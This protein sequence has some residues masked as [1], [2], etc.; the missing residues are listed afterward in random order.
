MAEDTIAPSR[1]WGRSTVTTA[2]PLDCPDSCSLS[3]TVERGQ[4]VKIDGNTLAPSTNGYICGKV[5]RF[6]RRVYSAERLLHP[7]IRTGPKGSATFER[8]SWDE[9]LEVIVARIREAI[10][11]FGAESVL[12]Y[13]YGGSN[14]LLTNDLEDARFFRRLGASRLARTLCAA[15]TGAAA[16]AMYGKMP[17][18]AYS[19]YE[20]ARLVV[21]WGSNPSASGIHLVSHIKRAQNA[22]AKLVVIDP[23][24]TPLARQ[25]D[26]HLAVRPG[27]DLPV[28]LSIINELFDRGWADESFLDRHADGA[29][30]LRQAAARWPIARAAVEAGVSKDALRTLAEWY[31]TISPAVIRCGWGQ[32]RNRNGGSSTLAV[33]ALPAVGG[34]FGVR[35]GGYT[36]SNSS[37]W[38]ITAEQLIDTPAPAT[39]I[40][41]M[42]QLGRALT[43][44]QNP[45]VSVL[46]VYN[47][48]PLATVP[49]QNRV[50]RGLAREDLFTIVHEQV[51][52][53]TAEFA[54]LL[55]P[56]PTF[57]EQYDVAKGYGA[58]HL[59]LVQ[60][61]INAIG[62]SR[63]NHELF[64][65]LGIRL[66]VTEPGDD[67]GEAGA[68]LEVAARLP[69]TVRPALLHEGPLKTPGDGQPIQ[70]VDVLPKTPNGRI[71][72]F[73]A[74][75]S[76]R[77]GL[78][79]VRAGPR[80]AAASAQPHLPGERAHHLVD[81]RRAA[82]RDRAPQDPSR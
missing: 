76:S 4:L 14:G 45:P 54:D 79:A 22:G 8:L 25:S 44:Y 7:A 51:M 5:R 13:Y 42:N 52:T 70:L 9:A 36:M 41:N 73:P 19:D 50:R 81:T 48:N 38:G 1:S 46:F 12:P 63:P 3:V 34:K 23:R 66:G 33:L 57:L 2:C 64:R 24:Q 16:S 11:Q 37:A 32:E 61:V 30:D 60:P 65:E 47:C 21:V 29:A 69:E 74:D 28:A 35:G 18:V 59:H 20:H 40:V 27:T 31:G 71:Q 62:E 49:D 10:A 43:E 80:D 55:L 82:T 68:L 17:G 72:L 15:P 77:A 6:D 67:L 39:R 75:L 78:Y 26:L 56:A 53:D 58:Y